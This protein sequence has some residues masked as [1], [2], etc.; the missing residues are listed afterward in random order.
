MAADS[1]ASAHLWFFLG[2]LWAPGS[3]ASQSGCW[4]L[5]WAVWA[6]WQE[7]WHGRTSGLGQIPA[8]LVWGMTPCGRSGVCD[9]NRNRSCCSCLGALT[10]SWN[11]SETLIPLYA[12]EMIKKI[13]T[14]ICEAVVWTY[15]IIYV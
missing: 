2:L 14:F 11:L 1:R 7:S 5:L 3:W 13:I 8:C 15:G 6:A 9:Q 4:P 12:N 10:V